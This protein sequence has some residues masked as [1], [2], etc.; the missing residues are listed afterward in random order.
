MALELAKGVNRPSVNRPSVN[1][2]APT[3]PGTV[4]PLVDRG[5]LAGLREGQH[6]PAAQRQRPMRHAVKPLTPQADIQTYVIT[7]NA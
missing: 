2:P 7:Y 5:R 4:D 1:R 6:D 3:D